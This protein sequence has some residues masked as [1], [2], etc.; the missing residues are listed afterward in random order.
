MKVF[1]CLL[2]ICI[3]FLLWSQ[4][5][6]IILNK[7]EKSDSIYQPIHLMQ[8]D[9]SAGILVVDENSLKE[10]DDE[11]AMPILNASRDPFKSAA[12]YQFSAMRFQQKGLGSNFLQVTVNGLI[13]QDPA[14]GTGLWSSWT[15]LN[16]VFKMS[17]S[18]NGL[19]QNSFAVAAIGES[20][21]V[22]IRASKQRPQATIGFAFSNRTYT[23][24]LQVTHSTGMLKNG[25]A[26]SVNAAARLNMFETVPGVFTN[27]GSYYFSADKK[28][29][30]RHLLSLAVF[31]S[32]NQSGKQTAILKESKNLLNNS[33]YNP[34]WG[35]QNGV[36]RNSSI[37]TQYLPVLILTH[38]FKLSNQR[39]IQTAIA[40]SSGN[41]SAT[42]LD[43]YHTPDPRPDYYRY[44][45]SY[46]TDPILQ[47]QLAN[48][49]QQRI[50]LQQL[51]WDGFFAVNRLNRESIFNANG[52]VGNTISGKR[53]RYIVENRMAHTNR[54]NFASSY[55][56]N[57]ANKS[58]FSM[59]LY[60]QI[61][62]THYYKTV[63]DL[64]G[65]DFYVN[66]NQFAETDLLNNPQAIQNDIS[67]PNRIL[68]VGDAF[69][70]DYTMVHHKSAIWAQTVTSLKRME[71][72][73]A[74]ELSVTNFFRVGNVVNGL[75]A[76][77]SFG[78]SEPDLF[79]NTGMKIGAN[80]NLNG[81]ESFYIS[82][83]VLSKPPN[84]ENCFISPRTRD[85]QQADIQNENY[86]AAETGYLMQ[87][88]L[89]KCRMNLYYS[90]MSNGMDV[91][92]F[93]HDGYNSFVNYAI[94][95]IGQ[96]HIGA[97]FGIETK[98]DQQ[99]SFQAAAAI[100]DNYFNSR[101]FAVVTADNTTTEIER[102]LVYAKNFKAGTA[103]QNAYS[104]G[105]TYRNSSQWF[106][107]ANANIFDR[108]WIGWNPIKRTA[109]AIY[110]VDPSTEKGAQLLKQE[111]LPV[112]YLANLFISHRFRVGTKK[113]SQWECS[114]SISNL[115]N[116]QDLVLSAYE[117]LRFD[118]DN[119]DANKFPPKYFY[120]MG[121]NYSLSLVY[122]Y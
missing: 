34:N 32:Y 48:N 109:E 46:Q 111:K 89:V 81:R 36:V 100:G 116:K 47:E 83:A 52:I 5:R 105:L 106:V 33:H 51:N 35:Y 29:A 42:G 25:W 104:L 15:G 12:A 114:L 7:I 115:L 103:P 16:E 63:N 39:F 1:A 108:Q 67:I 18:S 40:I 9:G 31:G 94:S 50:D 45:P 86:L 97:E 76:K 65:A 61:Q 3:P 17:E 53:A 113:T 87:S 112:Q 64:L 70:Y 82:A 24:R 88:P 44:L 120:G 68:T 27:G 37:G 71:L 85:T 23:H 57:L 41:K 73:I 74:S 43:W 77:N 84:F 22:E 98:L 28:I 121:L 117:Q 4:Q 69:G 30:E 75:F 54:L 102:V 80:Y 58:L 55:H 90:I 14:T 60:S 95:G 13:M 110:P 2:L 92:S 96:T 101:Q 49:I 21:N 99:F 26:F 38:E 6:K 91:L 19:N 79:L 66:W 93:Y 62:S 72:Y 107:V 119:K 59:G 78:R 56:G 122:R 11:M 10:K 8:Q 20:S 118:F